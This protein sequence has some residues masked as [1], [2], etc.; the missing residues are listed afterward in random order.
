MIE[1]TGDSDK[2]NAMEDMFR[3][4]GIK[5]TVRTGMIALSRGKSD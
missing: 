3:A 5:E 4:Y 2:I 1:A